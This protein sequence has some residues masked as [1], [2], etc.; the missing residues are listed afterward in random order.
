MKSVRRRLSHTFNKQ[1]SHNGSCM[2][3]PASIEEHGENCDNNGKY[4]WAFLF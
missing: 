2:E 4:D 3:L 1:R